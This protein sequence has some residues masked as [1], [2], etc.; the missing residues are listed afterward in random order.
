V[1]GVLLLATFRMI[2][3]CAVRAHARARTPVLESLDG[4]GNQPLVYIDL[5]VGSLFLQ[6]CAVARAATA[7]G[8]I[9]GRACSLTSSGVAAVHAAASAAQGV[10]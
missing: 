1:Q 8:R 2:E 9:Q 6:F 4:A 5:A 10:S 7:R 3:P